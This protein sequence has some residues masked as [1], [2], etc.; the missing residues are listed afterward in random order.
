MT[1]LQASRTR[2]ITREDPIAAVHRGKP[3]S[4]LAYIKA[5]Q[6]GEIP[7]PPSLPSWACGSLT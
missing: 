3:I 5:L 1:N 7:L 4:G 6:S 2:V